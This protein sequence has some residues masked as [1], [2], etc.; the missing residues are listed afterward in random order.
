MAINSK[1]NEADVRA[2]F[3]QHPAMVLRWD[4][5]SAAKVNWQ[6]KASN[7]SALAEELNLGVESFLFIDDNPFEIDL[8]RQAFPSILTLTV[9]AESWKLPELLPACPALDRL[10]LTAEDRL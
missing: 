8:V 6:D 5:F 9:P 7:M 3:E 2:V 1:N 10:D 4:D